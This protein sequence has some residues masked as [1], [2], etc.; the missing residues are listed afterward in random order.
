MTT[1]NLHNTSLNSPNK[2]RQKQIHNSLPSTPK[3]KRLINK[4]PNQEIRIK[5]DY[6]KHEID[7]CILK[8]HGK[9]KYNTRFGVTV[10]LLALT[11]SAVVTVILGLNL[12]PAIV[13]N[14]VALILS[15]LAGII[16]SVSAFFDFNE[17]SVKYKDTVD[18]FE[19]LKIKIEYFELGIQHATLE[20]VALL[21]EEYLLILNDTYAFFQT[22]R[23][24]ESDQTNKD[25][26]Q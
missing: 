20:D 21:K 14:R 11:L 7:K 8:F 1:Q 22:I 15:A 17:L 4:Q 6:L 23:N 24:D 18:K 13:Y 2:A 3:G 10:K 12:E 26:A 16:T 19:M 9:Q 25:S 5:V